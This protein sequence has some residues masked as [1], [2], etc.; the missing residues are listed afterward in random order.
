MNKLQGL[1]KLLK[2]NFNVPRYYALT[3]D[4]LNEYRR[5]VEYL[6][7]SL[8]NILYNTFESSKYISI[9][10]CPNISMPGMMETTLNVP[11]NDID[12]IIKIIFEIYDS[13]Y[14]KKATLYRKIKNIEETSPTVILQEMVFGNFNDQSG[15]GVLFTHDAAGNPFPLIEY[16][17]KA[18][19]NEIVNNIFDYLDLELIDDNILAQLK[20]IHAKILDNFIYPQDIEFTV[21]DGIVYLLQTRRLWFGSKLDYDICLQLFKEGKISKL[22]FLNDIEIIFENGKVYEILKINNNN[23]KYISCKAVVSGFATGS[24]GKDILYADNLTNEDIE[25]L[26]NY[27]AVITKTG[28]LTSHIAILCRNLKIPYMISTGNLEEIMEKNVIID[29]Y[30]GKIYYDSDIKF[31]TLDKKTAC[32]VLMD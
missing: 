11:I 10:S 18:Q 30:T 1:D 8:K 3:G 24:I 16:R 6:K 26:V 5:D 20:D 22:Q 27:R 25:L 15:S 17:K 23:L 9:R 14:N 7:T 32:A 28:G 4:Q 31:I 12:N 19:G 21:Q 2:L 13:Y 29:G